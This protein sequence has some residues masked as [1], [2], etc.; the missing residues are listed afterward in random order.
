M[1]FLQNLWD[2]DDY[3]KWRKKEYGECYVSLNMAE[4]MTIGEAMFRLFSNKSKEYAISQAKEIGVPN[5]I[6]GSTILA[7]IG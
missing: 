7:I 4:K 3:E 1:T 2:I 5:E 6:I